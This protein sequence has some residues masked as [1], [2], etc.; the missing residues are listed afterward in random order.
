[1]KQVYPLSI[2]SGMSQSDSFILMLC[3]PI[4]NRQVPIFIGRHEAQGILLAKDHVD[5]RRPLTHQTMQQMM[6][7][8][9]L[10]LDSVSIDRVLDG[11]FYATLHLTDGF[12]PKEI[13]CRP[14][15]AVT[16]ALLFNAPIL[17]NDKVL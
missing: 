10:S 4:S 9:G 1:M 14:S 8:Y 12:N 17:M 7:V 6:E 3:E 11:I 16:M 15:D 13:D 5:T 2:Q